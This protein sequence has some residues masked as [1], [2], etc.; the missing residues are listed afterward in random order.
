MT[1]R[2]LI[3]AGLSPM[4]QGTFT[5]SSPH[6]LRFALSSNS[7]PVYY[8]NGESSI[9]S[10][11]L[12][13]FRIFPASVG[14]HAAR[15]EGAPLEVEAGRPPKKAKITASEGVG[16]VPVQ[17]RAVA[18]T[19]ADRG[20]AD[21]RGATGPSRE[22]T[23]KGPRPPVMR[24]LC[25]LPVCADEPFMSLGGWQTPNGGGKRPPGR[26]LGG[27]ISGGQ[28]VSRRRFLRRIPPRR[29]TSRHGSGFVHFALGG[30]TWEV[31]QVLDGLHYATALMD[32][33]RDAGRVIGDLSE[34][35]LSCIAKRKRS[36][37]D[38]ARKPW[39]PSRNAR[40][41]WKRRWSASNRSSRHRK[42]R[43]RSSKSISE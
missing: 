6:I 15:V 24:D 20:G 17:P 41:I 23:K 9:R 38:Q 14:G 33:V 39:R 13:V 2:W 21:L 11:R 42:A 31:G 29:A 34:R 40:R 19:W 36:G 3:E 37:P 1:E 26:L 43:I 27:P 10:R 25:R 28:G 4:P 5:T 12:G 30:S 32:R 7:S 8:R 16:A 18:A 22:V 35:N